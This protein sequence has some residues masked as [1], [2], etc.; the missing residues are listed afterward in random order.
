[1]HQ[2][3]DYKSGVSLHRPGSNQSCPNY[4]LFN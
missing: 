2:I 3:G 4:W 1:M